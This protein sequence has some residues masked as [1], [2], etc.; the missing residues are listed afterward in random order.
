MTD[1]FTSNNFGSLFLCNVLNYLDERLL[2]RALF[3]L[4]AASGTSKSLIGM[5]HLMLRE[6]PLMRINRKGDAAESRGVL[7]R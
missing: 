5:L 4:I 7:P 2:S 1:R 3:S 6:D